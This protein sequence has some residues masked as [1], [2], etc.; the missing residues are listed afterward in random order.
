MRRIIILNEIWQCFFRNI[1]VVTYIRSIRSNSS[2]MYSCLQSLSYYNLTEKLS[3]NLMY[4]FR[5]SIFIIH[6]LPDYDGK[7]KFTYNIF[8]KRLRLQFSILCTLGVEGVTGWISDVRIALHVL[9]SYE[10]E[11]HIRDIFAKWKE[12]QLHDAKII[13]RANLSVFQIVDG[14]NAR[15][16]GNDIASHRWVSEARILRHS[17]MPYFF[18]SFSQFHSNQFSTDSNFRFYILHKILKYYILFSK[19][20]FDNEKNQKFLKSNRLKYFTTI[21]LDTFVFRMKIEWK[22][23]L[24]LILD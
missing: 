15:F 3:K 8:L 21:R 16:E 23:Y 18:A 13:S 5:D 12:I 20:R 10:R 7:L 22:F 17:G 1:V 2:T 6:W 9:C 11:Q 24:S 14:K 19:S 4:S